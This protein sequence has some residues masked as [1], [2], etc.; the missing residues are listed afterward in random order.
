MSFLGTN[1]YGACSYVRDKF[2]YKNVR[3]IQEATLAY[4]TSLEDWGS[5]DC[6]YILLTEGAERMNWVDN[7]QRDRET[8]EPIVQEGLRSRMEGMKLPIRV[9]TVE[10]L[11]DG[12]TEEEIWEIFERAYGVLE[13]GDQLYLDLTHGYRY[14]PMLMMSLVHYAQFLKGV[15]ICH[16]SYGNYEGRDR[17]K[18]EALIVDL[19]PLVNL[20]EWTFAAGQYVESGSVVRLKEVANRALRPLSAEAK[21]R[22]F[23]L[24]NMN[25]FVRT[26]EEVVDERL[27]CRGRAIISAEK[28]KKLKGLV[29]SIEGV[30]V[31]ALMA[32]FE[33]IKGTLDEFDDKENVDN[34]YR[35][36]KWCFDNRLYQQASTI[37]KEYVVTF[38]CRRHG[39]AEDDVK[40]REIVDKAFRKLNMI[41]KA[42]RPESGEEVACL[43]PRDR[44]LS[45]CNS[46]EGV[47]AVEE[48]ELEVMVDELMTAELVDTFCS[49]SDVRNDYNHSG[50]RQNPVNSKKLVDMIRESMDKFAHLVGNIDERRDGD[51]G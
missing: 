29:C 39:L 21:G 34:C 43:S 7:G 49:L 47:G 27:T 36:A 38:F 1:N 13:E 25:M 48:K 11:P 31:K 26:L 5:D 3:F 30:N 32:I 2:K 8:H 19:M 16:V 46:V 42:E 50:M 51:A 33:K 15:K 9:E 22:D 18:N 4:L 28:M 40:C 24:N 20:Q 10:K 35:A 17:A 44:M 23:S 6:A 12:N 45:L 14:L 37:L 41:Y